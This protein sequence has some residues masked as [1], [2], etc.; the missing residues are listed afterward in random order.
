MAT[1][2][3]HA[4]TLG[5]LEQE[6]AAGTYKIGGWQRWLSR[7]ERDPD[8]NPDPL[9]DHINRVSNKLHRRHGFREYPFFFIWLSEWLLAISGLALAVS[10]SVSGAITGTLLLTLS[11]QPLVKTSVGLLLGVR[12]AYAYLWYIEP[13]FK[14][15]YASYLA[16]SGSARLV[17]HL[18][19]SIGTPTA[20]AL[21]C[22]QVA[23]L[24]SMLWATLIGMAALATAA[25]QIGA[26]VAEY[27]GLRQVAGFRLADLT[28]PA[29]AARE[30]RRLQG[31]G[32]QKDAS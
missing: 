14:M 24:G 32:R 31:S 17:L 3:T 26:F 12:Y 27:R 28:S 25:L 5:A 2:C 4:D 8:F 7:V 18:A 29:T 20:L 13:R 19:G 21:G 16:L 30:L 15:R 6:I 11:A 9:A 23:T 10:G 1:D 22:L